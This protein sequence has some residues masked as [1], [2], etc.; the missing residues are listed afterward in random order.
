[1]LVYHY[2]PSPRRCSILSALPSFENA[3]EAQC[4]AGAGL[5]HS[6]RRVSRP[7]RD[8]HPG[9]RSEPGQT[10]QVRPFPKLLSTALS[11]STLRRVS[12]LPSSSQ[13]YISSYPIPPPPPRLNV[14]IRDRL[15]A[16]RALVEDMELLLDEGRGSSA[17]DDS[18]QHRLVSGW[19]GGYED[20]RA[21][22]GQ[23]RG[24]ERYLV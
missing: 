21:A 6:G 17:A 9:P 14:N 1:M 8:G 15:S 22:Y 24:W 5:P 10:R 18:A 2:R 7:D 16:Y 19:R 12:L 3:G 23:A 11:N 4:A 13:T 20:A